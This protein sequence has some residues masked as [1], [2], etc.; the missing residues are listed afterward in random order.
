MTDNSKSDEAPFEVRDAGGG[1]GFGC[2][3]TRDIKAG[4]RVLTAYTRIVWWDGEDREHEIDQLI[5]IWKGL[6]GFEREQWSNLDAAWVEPLASDYLHHLEKERLGEP[7]LTTGQQNLFLRLALAAND[8]CFDLGIQENG[9]ARGLFPEAAK[10]NHSCDPNVIYECWAKEDCW[11]A[12]AG[13]DIAAGEELTITYIPNH[14]LRD[15][16]QARVREHWDFIC[17][18]KKCTES[19]DS[20]TVSLQEARDLANEIEQDKTNKSA[21]SDDIEKV[22][23][24]IGTRIIRLSTITSKAQNSDEHKWRQRELVFA[25][26]DGFSFH[27]FWGKHWMEGNDQGGINEEEGWKHL[28]IDRGYCESALGTAMEAFEPGHEMIRAL[29]REL[30]VGRAIWKKHGLGLPGNNA[31]KDGPPKDG[32]PKD[33]PPPKEPSRKQSPPKDP[34]GG[35]PPSNQPPPK[36]PP[37][38]KPPSNQPPPKDPA[39]NKPPAKITTTEATTTEATTTEATTTEAT[40]T[41]ATTTEAMT[42]E[43]MTTETTPSTPSSSVSEDT[44]WGEGDVGMPD[45]IFN[46]AP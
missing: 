12:F 8:N 27:R 13:R 45:A 46:I 29:Q 17:K 5:K 9:E 1:R 33:G 3:A 18:C 2:F 21:F 14:Q 39:S 6:D 38:G 30:R 19:E 43:V 22:I 37:G 31:P 44:D 35:K 42:A 16:R 11:A 4:E 34:P 25:L 41:E 26:W 20:Y 7:P 36:D 15:A 28:K 10:F 40:T 24:S 32:P 23:H